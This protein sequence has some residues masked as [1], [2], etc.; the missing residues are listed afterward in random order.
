[1]A[2]K[3]VRVDLPTG[4]PDDMI[5]LA[6]DIHGKHVAAGADSPLET[7]KM[8]KLN[9]ALTPA[10]AKHQSAKDLDAQA[11]TLRQDRDTLLGIA[12]GQT[13]ET[14]DTILNLL[15]YSRDALLLKYRGSEETLS[16]YGFKVVVGS[17]KSPT[18]K[19]KTP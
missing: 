6:Q 15:T 12:D 8:D 1:M 9:V 13:A 14:P 7:A 17:A 3:T 5:K 10:N 2:R 18:K 4:K 19:P 16:Q 11:Q